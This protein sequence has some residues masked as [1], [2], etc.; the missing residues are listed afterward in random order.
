PLCHALETVAVYDVGGRAHLCCATCREILGAVEEGYRGGCGRLETLLQDIDPALFLDP[1]TQL[2]ETLVVRHYVCP[3]CASF[4]DADVCR[5]GEEP[6]DDVVLVA[7]VRAA[8][9]RTAASSSA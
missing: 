7:P 9:S 8:T 2:D 4:L 6:Y 3:G 5:V 1:L